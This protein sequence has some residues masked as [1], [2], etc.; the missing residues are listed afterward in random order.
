MAT[1]S[2]C[3]TTL[4]RA[5]SV[6]GH[7]NR[8][9]R[10]PLL[11]LGGSIAT[12]ATG[13]PTPAIPFWPLIF[14]NVRLFFLGS[15]DFPPDAKLAAAFAL[16]AALKDGWRGFEIEARFPLESIAAAHE[17]VERRTVS[18]RVVVDFRV[19]DQAPAA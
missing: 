17:A 2:V 9:R 14:K 19:G 6:E 13:D 18:G 4:V 15:D 11:V 16:N 5:S 8:S 12:Y 7:G 1:G 10:Q 3:F